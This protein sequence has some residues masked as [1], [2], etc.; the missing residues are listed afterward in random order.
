MAVAARD[1][2]RTVKR[3]DRVPAAAPR[4]TDSARFNLAHG[5]AA[6]L[7]CQ[8]HGSAPG[9]SGLSAVA[10]RPQTPSRRADSAVGARL[11]TVGDGHVDPGP[12]RGAQRMAV[13]ARV[14]EAHRAEVGQRQLAGRAGRRL[15]H[16]LGRGERRAADRPACTE[17]D[18]PS[19]RSRRLRVKVA[20]PVARDARADHVAGAIAQRHV[21]RRTGQHLPPGA[22]VPPVRPPC[23]WSCRS[24]AGCDCRGRR[25]PPRSSPPSRA[26][27]PARTAG[28][29]QLALTLVKC[30]C[31]AT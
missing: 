1:G 2:R 9:A 16:D 4:R 12:G 31:T 28:T 5:A 30:P 17:N 6:D 27:E 24:A 14:A 23:R 26:S 3:R 21:D 18:L 10:R 20:A 7:K 15:D 29:V 22:V 11:A 13:H 25:G 19:V 8:P